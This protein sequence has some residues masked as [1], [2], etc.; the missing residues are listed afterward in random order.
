MR[1]IGGLIWVIIVVIGVI[2]SIV[3]N[4]KRA[5]AQREAAR[6]R[7]AAQPQPAQPAPIL[8]VAKPSQPLG[9][10]AIVPPIIVPPAPPARR[11]KAPVVA[12]QGH[13][14]AERSA[15]TGAG[16]PIRGMFGNGTALV[17]AVI[18]AEVL[19]LP[20]SQQEHSIWSPRHSDPSI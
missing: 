20:K 14:A 13:L 7:M 4:A 9:Q 18:A 15:G 2:S 3:K 17:R 11:V 6:P 10:I 8:Q 19:G 1:D 5:A 12:A 16:S